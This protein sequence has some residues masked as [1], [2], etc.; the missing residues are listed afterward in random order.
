M[1]AL[2][3]LAAIIMIHTAHAFPRPDL[4]VRQD[5]NDLRNESHVFHHFDRNQ[6]TANRDRERIDRND[7]ERSGVSVVKRVS[8]KRAGMARERVVERRF[9]EGPDYSQGGGSGGGGPSS[10]SSASDTMPTQQPPKAEK[11]T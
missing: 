1:R 7:A 10:V 5:G 3:L 11:Q 9:V 8:K 4:A 2:A 6:R